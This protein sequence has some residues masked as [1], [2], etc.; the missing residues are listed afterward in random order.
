MIAGIL[1]LLFFML[2]LVFLLKLTR[3]NCRI[4][5]HP[6]TASLEKNLPGTDCGVCGY[7]CNLYAKSIIDQ[8]EELDLCKPGSE[9]TLHK[10][11]VQL[12]L[13]EEIVEEPPQ[14]EIKEDENPEEGEE[15]KQE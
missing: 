4:W 1:L 7:T 13:E 10:I 11:K 15:E 8:K 14:E 9:K 5:K 12:G 2:V 3:E 6:K